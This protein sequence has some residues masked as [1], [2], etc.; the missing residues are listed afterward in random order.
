MTIRQ[1]KEY[2]IGTLAYT[3]QTKEVI[4]WLMYMSEQYTKE[5]WKA[6][7]PDRIKPSYF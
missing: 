7:K 5:E 2:P 6:V 3:N 4:Q 1:I